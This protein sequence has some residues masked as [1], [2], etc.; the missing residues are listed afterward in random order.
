MGHRPQSAEEKPRALKHID[1]VPQPSK[2]P[3]G[4]SKRCYD[5][6]YRPTGWENP[7]QYEEPPEPG[8]RPSHPVCSDGVVGLEHKKW[9]PEVLFA[10]TGIIP[11]GLCKAPHGSWGGWG[12]GGTPGRRRQ[13]GPWDSVQPKSGTHDPAQTE[14]RFC[15]ARTK[16]FPEMKYEDTWHLTRWHV[17]PR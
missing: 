14:F 7:V 12:K 10:K 11:P 13:D 2:A 9:F 1:F 3:Q 8:K 15:D 17:D 6:V 4:G 16:A 5:W